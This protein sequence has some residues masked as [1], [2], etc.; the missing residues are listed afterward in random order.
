M[1]ASKF[2]SAISSSTSMILTDRDLPCALTGGD[3]NH[4]HT[5][6]D[7][8]S[9]THSVS[10]SETKNSHGSTLS[11]VKKLLHKFSH[12][13]GSTHKKRHSISSNGS[14]DHVFN[15]LPLDN[16]EEA[17]ESET[18]VY[19]HYPYQNGGRRR[20]ADDE[21]DEDHQIKPLQSSLAL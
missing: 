3:A 16:V 7:T 10:S 11:K 12:P 4:H 6:K 15:P 20:R 13:G 9:D 17:A 21:D 8:G 1:P 2:P 5:A 19:E 18:E 14:A